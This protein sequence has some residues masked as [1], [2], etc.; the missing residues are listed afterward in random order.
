MII[1]IIIIIIIIVLM[2]TIIIMI[3]TANHYNSNDIKIF[4]KNALLVVFVSIGVFAI[5]NFLNTF[6]RLIVQESPLMAAGFELS[7]RNAKKLKGVYLFNVVIF[8]AL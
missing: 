6:T 1:I 7:K 2:L 4:E 5:F 8:S 3:I